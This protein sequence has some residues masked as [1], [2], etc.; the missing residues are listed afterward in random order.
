MKL[1]T[2]SLM[3][4]VL[5]LAG[6]IQPHEKGVRN[7]SSSEFNE[8]S[9]VQTVVF[10]KGNRVMRRENLRKDS[11][12]SEEQEKLAK[13]LS[14]RDRACMKA[15]FSYQNRNEE[16]FRDMGVTNFHHTFQ[17]RY[18]KNSKPK[19]KLIGIWVQPE[20]HRPLMSS[21]DYSYYSDPVLDRMKTSRVFLA[22]GGQN[23]EPTEVI[24]GMKKLKAERME[25]F[26]ENSENIRENRE[27][28]EDIESLNS[29][30]GISR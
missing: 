5:I 1:F 6:C 24:E 21:W 12:W 14:L 19:L 8:F 11:A 27:F 20:G 4:A 29:E 28:T 30:L 18:D 3:S 13:M 23:C 9:R 7:P 10:G 17:F 22:D 16:N 25:L 26:K 2:L 15:V